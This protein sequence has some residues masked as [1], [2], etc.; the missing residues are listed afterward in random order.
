MNSTDIIKYSILGF[1]NKKYIELQTEGIKERLSKF[2]NGRLYLEIGGKLLWD[3]HAARVLPGF[4]PENKVKIL[5][6]IIHQAEIIF[7]IDANDILNDRQ[8]I[9]QPISYIRHALSLL[10]R[11][12]ATFGVRPIVVI[13]RCSS[14]NEEALHKVVAKFDSRG[15]KIYRRHVIEDYP[16]NLSRIL[17]DDGFGKDDYV[18]LTKDI[19]IVTG[20]AANSGKLSTCLGQLYLDAQHGLTSG[21]AKYETFPIWNLPLNHPVNIAYEAATADI[22]DYN[23]ID[24]FHKEH[25]KITSVNYNRDLD[26]FLL[27]RKI[28]EKTLAPHNFVR[29]YHSPTDMGINYAG[30][31]ITNDKIV[32][33]ASIAEIHRRI[34]W[35]TE[36]SERKAGKKEWIVRCEEL[37]VKAKRFKG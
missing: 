9:S 24:I 10:A 28:A 36:L 2:K 1:D 34:S 31:A 32:Q 27:L 33:E 35:F 18:K 21:Y 29:K 37:L 30:F 8:L 13:N 23:M 3:P 5:K 12:E 17:S 15:Y 19:V 6:N 26:A 14:E 16:K 11:I 7:S 22:G 20:P 4:Q 25:Y